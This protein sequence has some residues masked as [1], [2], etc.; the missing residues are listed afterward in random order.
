MT[1]KQPKPQTDVSEAHP[2]IVNELLAEFIASDTRSDSYMAS[3]LQRAYDAGLAAPRQ[4]KQAGPN[5]RNI[6][7]DLLVRPEGCTAR[8]IL[9]AT[10]W[11]SISIP[12]VAKAKGLDLRKEK[13]AGVTRYF[14]VKK[15]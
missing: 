7:A 8:E 10:G 12:S 14:G 13:D 3:L 9:D 2:E 1:K 11:T 15:S 5:K 4:R 6:A